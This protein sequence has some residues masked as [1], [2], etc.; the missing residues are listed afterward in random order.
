MKLPD[1]HFNY[2]VNKFTDSQM[3]DVT[4]N[5]N[6]EN[7]TLTCYPNP[8]WLSTTFSFKIGKRTHVSL[9]IYDELGREIK[10]LF[11]GVLDPGEYNSPFSSESLTNGVYYCILHTSSGDI[12]TSVMKLK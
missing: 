2:R 6:S 3:G 8:F 12:R 7:L 1:N 10:N 11:T 9:A 5:S 4:D